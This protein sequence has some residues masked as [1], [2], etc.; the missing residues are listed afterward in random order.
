[1]ITALVAVFLIAHGLVHLAVWAGP[2]GPERPMSFSPTHSWVL[3]ESGMPRS[4]VNVSAVSLA[5]V[6]ALLYVIAGAAAA[7]HSGGWPDAAVAAAVS[8]LVLKAVW[9]N[10]WLLVGVLLD[11]GVLAAVFGQWPAS[12]Y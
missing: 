7:A 11:A 3:A 10:P 4:A 1:M 9:F 6:T 5:A 8:G 12:L 2:A